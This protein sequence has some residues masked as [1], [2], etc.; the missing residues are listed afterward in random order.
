MWKLEEVELAEDPSSWHPQTVCLIPR[1][2]LCKLMTPN[3]V[4]DFFF[5]H[6]ARFTISCMCV[7]VA[8]GLVGVGL[9]KNRGSPKTPALSGSFHLCSS[10]RTTYFLLS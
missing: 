4:E 8:G 7:G 3:L 10:A 1:E 5:F 2:L 6:F 9:T